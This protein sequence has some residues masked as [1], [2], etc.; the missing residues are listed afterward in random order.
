MERKYGGKEGR[1]GELGTA[2]RLYAEVK[3]KRTTDSLIT[4][5]SG[6][7]QRNGRHWI[8]TTAVAVDT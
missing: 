2:V 3:D 1:D 8:V 4:E 7:D 6:I 5:R